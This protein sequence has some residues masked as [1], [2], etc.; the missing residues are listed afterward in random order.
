M[1]RRVVIFLFSLILIV[2]GCSNPETHKSKENQKLG[3]FMGMKPSYTPQLLAPDLL[4]SSMDEY[5]SAFSPDG[6]EFFFTSYLQPNLGIISYTRMNEDGTWIAPQVASFSGV[7]SEYDPLFS[8]DGKRIYFSSERPGPVDSTAK[9]RIWFSEK[10]GGAWAEPVLAIED[11]SGVY[12][13]SVTSDGHIYLNI[14]DTGDMYKVTQSDSGYV[15][16]RLDSVLNTNN[17]EADPFISPDEDY[18]IFRGYND[19][20]GRGDL[21]ISYNI[22]GK[23]S[24]AQNLGEPINS[25]SHEMCPVVSPD[26]KF[27]LWA[28]GRR[29]NDLNT[30][31]GTKLSEIRMRSNSYDNRRMNLFYISA[32]FI[33]EMQPK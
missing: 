8:P 10:K 19:S 32:D 15:I 29:L 11:S 26:G 33:K 20:F 24:E 3:V 4:A 5:N 13:S 12:H 7:F 14:W 18:M 27:F 17:S 28:S 9:T 31:P 30:K 1:I 6:T 23:W 2:S 16:F 21:Y 25:T 22:D